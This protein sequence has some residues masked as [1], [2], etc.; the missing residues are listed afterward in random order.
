MHDQLALIVEREEEVLAAATHRLH[1]MTD[2]ITGRYELAVR[3]MPCVDDALA[4]E[5]RSDLSPD[6]LDLGELGHAAEQ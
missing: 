6:G 1:A 5:R 2:D 3:R 4:C